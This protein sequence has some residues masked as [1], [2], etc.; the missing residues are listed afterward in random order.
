MGVPEDEKA[1]LKTI[2]LTYVLLIF[3]GSLMIIVVMLSEMFNPTI[4][5]ISFIL[6]GIMVA[7]S[8][9]VWRGNDVAWFTS[10]ILSILW[11]ISGITEILKAYEIIPLHDEK[12]SVVYALADTLLGLLM[13]VLLVQPVVIKNCRS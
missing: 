11:L 9:L 5:T 8:Y 7:L 12:A 3:V 6:A 13:I 10:L 4:V 2:L 1:D